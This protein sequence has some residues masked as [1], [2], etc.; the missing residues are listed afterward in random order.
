MQLTS[1]RLAFLA[2]LTTICAAVVADEPTL[3]IQAADY[4]PDSFQPRQT[5]ENYYGLPL[6]AGGTM[7]AE[8]MQALS[9]QER[10]RLLT[11]SHFPEKSRVQNLNTIYSQRKS[12]AENI[13]RL[14]GEGKTLQPYVGMTLQ[15]GT[16]VTAEML[17]ELSPFSQMHLRNFSTFNE[18]GRQ[19]VL[20]N[21]FDSLKREQASWAETVA[22]A[23]TENVKRLAE[24]AARQKSDQER[25]QRDLE[26]AEKMK[27]DAE[28]RAQREQERNAARAKAE[29]DRQERDRQQQLERERIERTIQEDRTRLEQER[30]ARENQQRLE[31]ERRQAEQA[32]PFAVPAPAPAP[33]VPHGPPSGINPPLRAPKVRPQAKSV[34]QLRNE[35]REQSNNNSSSRFRISAGAVKG[36]LGLLFL[37]FCGLAAGIRMIYRAIFPATPPE[38]Q[39]NP[40]AQSGPYAQPPNPFA[41]NNNDPY[42]RFGG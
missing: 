8:A 17:A 40:F 37:M 26:R 23:E 12:Y 11:F 9:L 2:F 3:P 42:G 1:F 13:A 5:L 31:E 25:T 30:L 19:P 18:Q 36:I 10:T 32:I 39:P 4:K 33:P 38:V 6:E 7:T 21:A 20:D 35:M 14:E 34:E 22:K 27:R 29:Q 28:E 24:H 15:D 16:K 41:P